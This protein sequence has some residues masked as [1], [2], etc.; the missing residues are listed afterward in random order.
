MKLTRYWFEMD[1]GPEPVIENRYFEVTAWTLEDAVFLLETIIFK[2]GKLPCP[3]RVTNNI[4]VSKLDANHV[5]PN[6]G[7]CTIRGIWYPQGY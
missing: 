1:W 4:D 2:S 7:V 5:L 3:K 6:M